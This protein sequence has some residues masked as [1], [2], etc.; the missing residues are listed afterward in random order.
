MLC[1]L[2]QCYSADEAFVTGT[3]AGAPFRAL[4]FSE[5]CDQEVTLRFPPFSRL[6]KNWKTNLLPLYVEVCRSASHCH[7]ETLSADGTDVHAAIYSS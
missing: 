3:F 2:V 7:K 1:A 6:K 5:K 4:D